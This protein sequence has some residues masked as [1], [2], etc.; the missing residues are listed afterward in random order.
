MP[1]IE[2]APVKWGIKRGSASG[3][4]K[5]QNSVFNSLAVHLHPNEARAVIRERVFRAIKRIPEITPFRMDAPFTLTITT[6]PTEGQT[7]GEKFTLKS[8]DFLDLMDSLS[9]PPR[10]ARK[11]AAR[12][13]RPAKPAAQ[14]KAKKSAPAKRGKK[15]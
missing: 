1:N 4:T 11:A 9:R 3:L 12:P 6:R 13:A 15:R 14:V 7:R 2:V 10:A 5:E 8:A